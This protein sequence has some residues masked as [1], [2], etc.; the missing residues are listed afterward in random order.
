MGRFYRNN[1]VFL[2]LKIYKSYIL[3]YILG[4]K[5]VYWYLCRKKVKDDGLCSG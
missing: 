4:C 2:K 3:Y 5:L 1:V